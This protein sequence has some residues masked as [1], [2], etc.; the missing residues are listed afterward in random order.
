MILKLNFTR[1]LRCAILDESGSHVSL[2]TQEHL[3]FNAYFDLTA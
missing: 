3:C 2:A 1:K